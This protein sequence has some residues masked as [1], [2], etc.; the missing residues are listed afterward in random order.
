MPGA[1][2]GNGLMGFEP[3]YFMAI[4]RMLESG[5]GPSEPGDGFSELLTLGAGIEALLTD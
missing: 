2:V 5:A 1:L 3:S 4:T